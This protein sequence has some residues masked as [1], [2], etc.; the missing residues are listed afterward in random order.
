MGWMCRTSFPGTSSLFSWTWTLC[1]QAKPVLPRCLLRPAAARPHQRWL[2]LERE[3]LYTTFSSQDNS[4]CLHDRVTGTAVRK[5]IELL[6]T[7]PMCRAG[8]VGQ[9]QSSSWP[10]NLVWRSFSPWSHKVLQQMTQ[11]S[12]SKYCFRSIRSWPLRCLFLLLL[13]PP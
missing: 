11:S 8:V 12:P 13:L 7:R 5:T 3:P 2:A 4:Y 10:R 9:V 6:V 1:L